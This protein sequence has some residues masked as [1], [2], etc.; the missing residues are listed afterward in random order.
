[1]TR[2]DLYAVVALAALAVP[3]VAVLVIALIDRRYGRAPRHRP[4]N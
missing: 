1:M 2:L 3:I 4:P